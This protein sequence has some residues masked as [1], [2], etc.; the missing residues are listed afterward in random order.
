MNTFLLHL[1]REHPTLPEAEAMA[2]LQAEAPDR[3]VDSKGPGYIV[4]SLLQEEM[5]MVADRIALCHSV[6]RYLGGCP[7]DSLERFLERMSL[8]EGSISV[9]V[10][11][12]EGGLPD[13]HPHPLA[14]RIG[15]VLAKG[16]EVDLE[17]PDLEIRVL[18]SDRLV[19]FL[20]D[21]PVPRKLFE[22]RKVGS[23]PYFSPISLHP[24]FA[25]ALVNLTRVRRGETL[26][27]PFCGT[28][29]VLMEASLIGARVMG[30]DLSPDMVEGAR[31]NLRHFGAG[32]ERL[33]VLDVGEIHRA[34]REVD[35]VATDP[36]Y[37]RSTS[38][39]REP[40]EGLYHRSID[41]MARVLRPGGWMGVV[42]PTECPEHPLLEAREGHLQRV[43]RSLSRRYCVFTRRSR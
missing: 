37:G 36:P 4:V 5:E 43:H 19:F 2:C 18:L 40:L 15:G 29:G 11:R 25:R 35:A 7:P 24:K 28:G 42:V 9:R 8:P 26:L 31:M 10:K 14:G 17:T 21:R 32:A 6:G 38:T 30:S 39:N 34:F 3:P 27:D 33:E 41:S 1:S 12:V 20:N 13:L 23:R 22:E 16:R